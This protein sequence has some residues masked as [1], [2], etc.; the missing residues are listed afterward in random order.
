MTQTGQ[1]PSALL[2]PGAEPFASGRDA[3]VYAIDDEWVLRR[4][5]DGHPVRHE[6]DYMRHVAKYGYPVPA[7]REIDGP[8]IVLQRLSG[9][10]VADAAIAGNLT[11]TELGELHADLH[12]RLHAIPA[13]SG[14]PGRVV[15]HGD[16]HPLNVIVTADGP[17]VID[18]CNAHEGSPAFD[19][20]M[21]AI[22]CAQVALDPS[23][24]ALTPM[25]HEALGVYL[26]NSVDPTPGLAD[27]LADRARNIT[28]TPEERALLP[29]QEELIRS[30]L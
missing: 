25:L 27:A 12:R 18:W 7:V 15:V 29:A 8:D 20:A 6:A 16:L 26:A 28:L 4:Y 19:V 14:T 10:T 1:P 9:P 30:Y 3:D 23:Y 2:P 5:R 17:V 21:T 13:P 11:G 24:E 22:I